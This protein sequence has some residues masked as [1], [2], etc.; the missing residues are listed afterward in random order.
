MQV[1]WEVLVAGAMIATAIYLA[2]GRDNYQIGGGINQGW[3]IE[4]R[5]GAVRMCTVSA[6]SPQAAVRC[7]LWA[8][9]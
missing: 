7:T 9:S 2:S 4:Q 8:P 1:R 6:N 5:S 3:V